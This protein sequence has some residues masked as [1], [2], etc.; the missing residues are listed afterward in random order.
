[1]SEYEPKPIVFQ[2]KKGRQYLLEGMRR[3]REEVLMQLERCELYLEAIT[4]RAICVNNDP[5]APLLDNEKD[6][7]C[8]ILDK[9]VCALFLFGEQLWYDK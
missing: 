2:T 1:M 5:D 8:D 3:E 9:N 4:D 6:C 7:L